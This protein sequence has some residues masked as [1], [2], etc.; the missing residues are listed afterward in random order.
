MATLYYNGQSQLF[1]FL[2]KISISHLII[3]F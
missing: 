2:S 1:F 3:S